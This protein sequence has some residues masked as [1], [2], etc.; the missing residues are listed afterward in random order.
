MK[1]ISN[2]YSGK[3]PKDIEYHSL[4]NYVDRPEYFLKYPRLNFVRFND[5]T[6]EGIETYLGKWNSQ[7]PKDKMFILCINKDMEPEA[8]FTVYKNL[9]RHEFKLITKM[10]PEVLDSYCNIIEMNKDRRLFNKFLQTELGKEVKASFENCP[11]NTAVLLNIF[12]NTR[13]FHKKQPELVWC[14]DI[15]VVTEKYT[16]VP[17]KQFPQMYNSIKALKNV[18]EDGILLSAFTGIMKARDYQ[19]HLHY[20]KVIIY[21]SDQNHIPYFSVID[22]EWYNKE[23]YAEKKAQEQAKVYEKKLQ[24]HTESYEKKIQ[25]SVQA[26]LVAQAE[27]YEKKLQEQAEF[28]EKKLL[29]E[30]N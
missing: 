18:T 30:R 3:I 5:L 15:M 24:D 12:V 16:W 21:F 17:P 13:G 28:Y 7:P 9:M 4:Y 25:E 19:R 29:L 22:D 11:D 23:I 10:D 8:I 1:E 14:K 27:E 2:I 6:P 20:Y 26:A